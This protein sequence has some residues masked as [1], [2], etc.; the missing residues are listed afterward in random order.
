MC[1]ESLR[2]HIAAQMAVDAINRNATIL[3]DYD[4]KL[5]VSDGQC[6]A[7]MVMKSLIDYLRFKHFNRMVGILGKC[8]TIFYQPVFHELKFICF[9]D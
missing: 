5:F 2:S 4:L 7:D 9:T 8:K 6:T 1:Y 3:R